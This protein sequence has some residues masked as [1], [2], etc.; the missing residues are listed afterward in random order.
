MPG[1]LG[2]ARPAA[3]APGGGY[4]R[5]T[6]RRGG[7]VDGA[8]AMNAGESRRGRIGWPPSVGA[9]RVHD[10]GCPR[11]ERDRVGLGSPIAARAVA[12]SGVGGADALITKAGGPPGPGA[13]VMGWGGRPP[14]PPGGSL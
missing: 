1:I 8:S 10:I 2:Q 13:G 6:V 9:R 11:A 3:K 5:C 4:G 14:E 12:A 7:G